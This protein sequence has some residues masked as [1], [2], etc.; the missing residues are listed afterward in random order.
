MENVINELKNRLKSYKYDF[1]ILD[2]Y[3]NTVSF[4]NGHLKKFFSNQS[5]VISLRI[6][7]NGREGYSSISDMSNVEF[8]VTSALYN[9][10]YGEKNMMTLPARHSEDISM[11]KYYHKMSDINWDILIKKSE[12]II[13]KIN[14]IDDKFKVN[15]DFGSTE[16]KYFLNN[17]SGIS[18]YE[19]SSSFSFG[20]DIEKIDNNSIVNIDDGYVYPFYIDEIDKVEEKIIKYINYYKNESTLEK[21]KYNI[22]LSPS[23]VSSVIS[24]IIMGIN[25]KSVYKKISPLYDKLN[26]KIV[27]EKITLTEN[28]DINDCIGSCI[29]DDEGIF[30]CKKD[31]VKDGHVNKFIYDLSIAYKMKTEATG[32]GFRGGSPKVHPGLTNLLLSPGASKISDIK[33]DL[34]D[35]IFI[36]GFI[37]AGQSN[38]IA[39]DFS[40]TIEPAFFFQ[41]NKLKFRIKD[42]MIAFNVYD[43]LKDNIVDISSDIE[44]MGSRK[45][46]FI[47]LKDINIV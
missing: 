1:V 32:N 34:K 38:M 44:N 6:F 14:K 24:P 17:S 12:D 18:N 46:P 11:Y 43:I 29:V 21:G 31:L 13:K 10:K 5:N 23:A 41:N 22:V 9:S 7:Y 28:P 47:V 19:L 3:S 8:L 45:Y 20:V 26:Q 25:G 42:N 27:S 33:K 15:I 39:G 36:Y 30:A 16:N 40:A 2:N 35:Y 4:E 37:G